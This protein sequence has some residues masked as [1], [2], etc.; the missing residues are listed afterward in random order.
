MATDSLTAEKIEFWKVL[1]KGIGPEL[2]QQPVIT[3]KHADFGTIIEEADLLQLQQKNLLASLRDINQRRREIAVAGEELRLRLAA[4]L[5][6]EFGFKSE[7]L[8]GFGV[9]PRRRVRRSRKAEE[10]PEVEAVQPQGG[11]E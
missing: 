4:V 3:A 6:A 11:K 5:Q 9:K 1:H 10:Q 2:V 8:I 7:K